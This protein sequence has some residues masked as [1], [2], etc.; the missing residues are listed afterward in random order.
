M[1]RFIFILLFQWPVFLLSGQDDICNCT[2]D[3]RSLFEAALT[4]QT[5]Q[6]EKTVG[7]QLFR[8]SWFNG[9]IIL[10]SGDTVRDEQIGYNGYHDELIWRMLSNMSLIR[11]DREQVGRFILHNNQQSIIFKHLQGTIS[12]HRKIDFFAQILVEDTISLFVT[13]IIQ[14][15]DKVEEKSGGNIIYIDRIEPA[16]PVY[17]ICLP[18]NK[19]LV[20]RYLRKKKL[21]DTFPDNKEAIRTILIQHHQTLRKENDL[22]QIVQLLNKYEVIK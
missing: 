12:G 5:C 6:I 13:R 15:V 18:H 14:L 7:S 19:F 8:D 20:M 21:Y 9:D 16:P 4:G 11:V 10:I 2:V 17:Y 22:L 3:Q 1:K